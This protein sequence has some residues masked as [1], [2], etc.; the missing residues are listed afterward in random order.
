[1]PKQVTSV[2]RIGK[3]SCFLR[4]CTALALVTAGAGNVERA[5][6]QK[7]VLLRDP[8]VS[9]GQIAFSYAGS[10]W[11][12]NRDGSN[13]RRLTSSGHEGKPMFSPDGSLVAFTGDYD[14]NR[15]VYVVGAEGGDP[16]V[17]RHRSTPR[18]VVPVGN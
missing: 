7:P 1:M 5:Q 12:S 15:S 2:Q 4:A 6:A 14:G 3:A 17:G 11:I 13:V 8:S 16:A 18:Y 9:L 10:I